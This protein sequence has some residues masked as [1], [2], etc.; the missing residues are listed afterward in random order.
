MVEE[1]E[2]VSLAKELLQ[3]LEDW[4]DTSLET[5]ILIYSGKADEVNLK[6][7]PDKKIARFFE[8]IEKMRE[9]R[10]HDAIS[11]VYE[12]LGRICRSL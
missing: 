7:H 10:K 6:K 8:I 12:V 2:E 11:E 5:L 4:P 3:Y 9:E 1:V